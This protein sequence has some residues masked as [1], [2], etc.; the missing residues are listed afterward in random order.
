MYTSLVI[1]DALG[2]ILECNK[3]KNRGGD[4]HDEQV[5]KAMD[6]QH[7]IGGKHLLYGRIS[8][9]W[10]QA[11]YQYYKQRMPSKLYLIET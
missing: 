3:E 1:K 7:K 5:K 10:K 9:Q 2:S 6:A 11:Q 8:K 4:A